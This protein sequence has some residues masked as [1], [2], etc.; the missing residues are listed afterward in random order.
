MVQ[1]GLGQD[2]I[3][4][5]LSDDHL[6]IALLP[7]HLYHTTLAQQQE[8]FK[9][10]LPKDIVEAQYTSPGNA[11]A[12]V[13]AY[14]ESKGYTV[15]TSKIT[16]KK[17]TVICILPCT[18]SFNCK[19]IIVLSTTPVDGEEMWVVNEVEPNHTQ[20]PRLSLRLIL[21]P[22]STN[23]LTGASDLQRDPTQRTTTMLACPRGSSHWLQTHP[24]TWQSL[25]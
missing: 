1:V 3:E 19:S 9:L 14:A 4:A 2:L 7:C 13:Q 21:L 20:S 16:K 18:L 11:L 23:L 6:T 15:W 22:L 17:W 10:C 12:D 5:T 25:R 24:P 8:G